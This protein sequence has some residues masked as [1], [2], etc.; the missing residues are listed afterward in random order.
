M[1]QRIKKWL[2]DAVFS[3]VQDDAMG[4]FVVGVVNATLLS[5]TRRLE[6]DNDLAV[7]LT[8]VGNTL[9]RKGAAALKEIDVVPVTVAAMAH[10]DKV[11]TDPRVSEELGNTT[12][13]VLDLASDV[14]N[15]Q[16]AHMRHHPL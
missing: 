2:G 14:G 5:V 3:V 15:N 13:K 9:L 4:E 8:S 6:R 11:L 10:V 1:R 7:A 16:Q 12:S